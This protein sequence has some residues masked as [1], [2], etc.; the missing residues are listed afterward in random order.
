MEGCL[1]CLISMWRTAKRRN[2][3]PVK[4]EYV[5]WNFVIDSKKR[6]LCYRRGDHIQETRWRYADI[7]QTSMNC[8]VQLKTVKFII[9]RKERK[10]TDL[11]IEIL[12]V[13]ANFFVVF[14]LLPFFRN[15]WNCDQF[16]HNFFNYLC[17]TDFL[18]MLALFKEG[19][20]NFSASLKEMIQERKIII[21]ER[22]YLIGYWS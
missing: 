17:A 12:I 14:A 19:F 16:A 4:K 15:L 22:S 2:S 11:Y 3:H 20:W 21:L 8:H 10:T 9:L 7:S 6:L 5:F 18:R 1:I 13:Q